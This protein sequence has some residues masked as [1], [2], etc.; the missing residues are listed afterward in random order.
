MDNIIGSTDFRM[1]HF[2]IRELMLRM[3]DNQLIANR[4][5]SKIWDEQ[6]QVRFIESVLC[7]IPI[8]S[9][10]FNGSTPQW[11]VLDGVERLCA[12]EAFVNNEFALNGLELLYPKYENKFFNDFPPAVRRRLMNTSVFGYVLTRELPQGILNSI[13]KRLNGD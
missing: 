5:Q 3:G 10:Y 11:S 1:Q 8:A 13:F 7:G 2:S 4:V 9:L 12:I 6:K